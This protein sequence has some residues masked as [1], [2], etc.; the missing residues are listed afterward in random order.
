MLIIEK[1]KKSAKNLYILLEENTKKDH[2]LI[3]KPRKLYNAE[4]EKKKHK[5]LC[6]REQ[7]NCK[8]YKKK[9]K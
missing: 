1:L 6:K 5:R 4:K 7:K 2:L 8:I 9:R 3:E